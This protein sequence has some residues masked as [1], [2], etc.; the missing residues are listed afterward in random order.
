MTSPKTLRSCYRSFSRDS[1][2]VHPIDHQGGILLEERIASNRRRLLALTVTFGFAVFAIFTLLFLLLGAVLLAPVIA[3]VVTAAWLIAGWVKGDSVVLDLCDVSLLDEVR[4]ARV[5]NVTSGLCAAMGLSVPDLYVIDDPALNALAVGR[6]S[7]RASLVVTQ[8]LLD[9]LTLVELEGVIA[10]QLYRI[11]AGDIGPETLV[12]PTFGAAAVLSEEFEGWQFISRLFRFGVPLVEAV[13][14]RL[15]PRDIELRTD[16]DAVQFTRY[17][18]ALAS[19]LAKMSGRSAV[20]VAAPVTAHLWAAPPIS[21]AARPA[22]TKVHAA[23][24]ERI[25]VLQEL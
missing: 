19:G 13:L 14:T 5:I 25:A 1:N 8:G 10:L 15:H 4:H 11:K 12:V 22:I 20:A 21:P 3:L 17:P 2:S 6:D 24:S 23:L 18:P 7:R 9:N 16:I